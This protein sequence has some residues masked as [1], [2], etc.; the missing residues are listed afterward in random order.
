MITMIAFSNDVPYRKQ[1][2]WEGQ[3][4][5]VHSIRQRWL[6]R[7]DL[8]QRFPDI[9][10]NRGGRTVV[11]SDPQGDRLLLL[12]VIGRLLRTTHPRLRRQASG[13]P[14]GRKPRASMGAAL[15]LLWG[16]ETRAV[17]V[18]VCLA[19]CSVSGAMF[20]VAL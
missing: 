3:P 2:L 9:R 4:V 15:P 8:N 19:R 5:A 16:F 12:R 10:H 13:K 18:A 7:R 14:Q 1:P 20:D 17:R 11:P 6:R